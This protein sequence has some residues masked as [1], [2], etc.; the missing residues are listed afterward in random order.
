MK[1]IIYADGGCSGNKRDAGCKG[2]WGYT[3]LDS[4]GT[5]INSGSGKGFNTTNNKMELTAVI[6]GLESLIIILSK[7]WGGSKKHDCEV[8]SDSKYVIDN[9]YD[10]LQ[11]WKKNGWKKS[12]GGT[13]L[14]KSLWKILSELTPEFKS[15]EFQWVKGH[16]KDKHNILVDAMAKKEFMT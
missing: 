14:N 9:Y 2:G 12:K 4:S 5:S 8:R 10:Y 15:L 16:D 6:K 11:D 13:V 1:F 7:Y 3:I